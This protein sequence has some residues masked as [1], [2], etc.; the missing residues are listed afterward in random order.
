VLNFR[1]AT[2]LKITPQATKCRY[3]FQRS[4]WTGSYTMLQRGIPH[5][6]HGSRNAT[7]KTS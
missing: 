2:T 3:S 7:A 6:I 4:Y 5:K 1:L